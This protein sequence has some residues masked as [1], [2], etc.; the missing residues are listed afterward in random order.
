MQK[1]QKGGETTAA[2][3]ASVH[4]YPGMERWY[5]AS[6]QD[7]S[8]RAA[9]MAWLAHGPTVEQQSVVSGQAR[10]ETNKQTQDRKG[11]RS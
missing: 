7:L 6:H 11:M 2:Y 8:S 3:T 1:Q 4:V 5:I 9:T 10:I